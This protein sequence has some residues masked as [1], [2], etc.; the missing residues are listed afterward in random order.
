M[1]KIYIAKSL[2][3][4]KERMVINALKIEEYLNSGYEIYEQEIDS[5]EE[6]LIA[7]PKD[8]FLNGKP[9]PVRS[10]TMKT[11]AR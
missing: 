7:T 1:D 4:T 5:L 10:Y 9:N 11:G 3:D 6:R 8:G 2:D